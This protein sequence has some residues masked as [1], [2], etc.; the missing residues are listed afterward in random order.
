MKKPNCRDSEGFMTKE[1]AEWLLSVSKKN[2]NYF[3]RSACDSTP[4]ADDLFNFLVSTSPHLSISEANCLVAGLVLAGA[5]L[6][7][8]PE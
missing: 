8:L 6:Y 5:K 4:C 3:D 7:K 2:T 1:Y